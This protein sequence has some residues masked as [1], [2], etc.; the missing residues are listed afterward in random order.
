MKF[1]TYAYRR[2]SA[3]PWNYKNEIASNEFVWLEKVSH[4]M[5]D[6]SE[7]YRLINAVEIPRMIDTE[8]GVQG[9]MYLDVFL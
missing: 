8:R 5:K 7:E 2:G 3:S 6:S 1:I 4:Y 9:S